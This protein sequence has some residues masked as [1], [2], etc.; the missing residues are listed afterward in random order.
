MTTQRLKPVAGSTGSSREYTA[1]RLYQ[2]CAARRQISAS[3]TPVRPGGDFAAEA[4]HKTYNSSN[5]HLA[6]NRANLAVFT[7]TIAD[8]GHKSQL[9]YAQCHDADASARKVISSYVRASSRH[10]SCC[11]S[12]RLIP[13]ALSVNT[14][15]DVDIV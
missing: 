15:Q 8:H 14:A 4:E 9:Y 6:Y 3:A 7:L 1:S 11:G 10:D 2:T 13:S 12:G 5:L